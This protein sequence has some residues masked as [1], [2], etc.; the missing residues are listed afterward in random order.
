MKKIS[1]VLQSL[2]LIFVMTLGVVAFSACGG[3]NNT[4]PKGPQDNYTDAL[5][6]LNDRLKDEVT[7]TYTITIESDLEEFPAVTVVVS[8]VKS[9]T[10]NYVRVYSTIDTYVSYFEYGKIGGVDY[11]VKE[12]DVEEQTYTTTTST[13]E[14]FAEEYRSLCGETYSF[15]AEFVYQQFLY[16]VSETQ[17][18][19]TITGSNGAYVVKS[20]PAEAV[21]SYMKIELE[22]Q[23]NLIKKAKIEEGGDYAV[24]FTATY[25]YGTEAKVPEN[26]QQFQPNE[27]AV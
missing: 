5:V 16:V 24:K 8:R 15:T 4:D 12:Y 22:F 14:D 26:L 3:N 13:S 6:Y 7:Q 10:E 17:N 21:G 1:K 11:V 23:D 9:E 25:T 20:E 27:E 18:S 2:M 19:K